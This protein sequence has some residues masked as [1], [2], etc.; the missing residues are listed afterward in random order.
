MINI[1]EIKVDYPT[2]KNI[3]SIQS[4]TAKVLRIC[5][6]SGCGKSTYLKHLSNHL[7]IKYDILFQSQSRTLPAGYN[8]FEYSKFVDDSGL[9]LKFVEILEVD[10]NQD[11]GFLSGGEIQRIVLAEALSSNCDYILLDEVF[12]AIDH[13]RLQK[14]ID[15]FNEKI[16]AN[17]TTIIYIAHNEFSFN[18][19]IQVFLD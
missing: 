12:N 7:A 1:P 16:N 13:K 8:S 15:L 17:D 18:K 10:P 2:I 3:S 19:E 4:E 14:T 6:K 5:G 11:F 9:F